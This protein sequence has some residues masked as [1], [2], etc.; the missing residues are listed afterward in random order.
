MVA[1][2]RT[3]RSGG[4]LVKFAGMIPNKGRVAALN[5]SYADRTPKISGRAQATNRGGPRES[6]L[7]RTT[8]NLACLWQI[9]RGKILILTALPWSDIYNGFDKYLIGRYCCM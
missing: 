8:K 7:D 1:C 2:E 3:V 4:G 5:C 6:V 9:S